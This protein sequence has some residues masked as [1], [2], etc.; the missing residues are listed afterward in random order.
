MFHPEVEVY[1]PFYFAGGGGTARIAARGGGG[2]GWHGAD[3]VFVETIFTVPR[4]VAYVEPQVPFEEQTKWTR[5][6]AS[7]NPLA[8]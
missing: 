4:S 5:L 8:S 6:A 7:A 1:A 3:R 2:E